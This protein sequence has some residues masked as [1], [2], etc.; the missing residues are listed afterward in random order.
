M[1]QHFGRGHLQLVALAPHRLDQDGKM[2]LAATHHAERLAGGRILHLQRHILEQFLMQAVTNLAAG[3]KFALFTRKGAVVDGKG[4]FDRRVVDLDEGQGFD[5]L[6]VAQGI[7]DVDVR[8][9][10]ER[11]D[12]A[13]VGG[14]N[15]SA[16]I[17]LKAVQRG[18]APFFGEIFVMPVAYG[19]LLAHTDGAVLHTPDADTAYKIVVVDRGAQHRKRRGGVALGRLDIIEDRLKQRLQILALNI[20][21]VACRARTAGAEYHRA[22][23]LL[24]RGAKVHQEQ[25]DLVDDFLDA[26]IGTV[27]LVHGDDKGKILL[28]GFLQHK[29]CL[30]H[31][32]LG[33]VHQKEHAVD[34]LQNAFHFAAE[35]GVARG[36]HDIDFHAVII[37]TGVFGKDGDAALAL[38]VAG[39]HYAL[40]NLLVFAERSA[41]LE[42]LVHER[43]LAV[44]DV[45]NDRDV[46][47]VFL[48]HKRSVPLFYMCIDFVRHNIL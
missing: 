5:H 15:G 27:D 19:H 41:L 24:V 16:A 45:G 30:G 3:D 33:G 31:A 42:H 11:D 47:N 12:I 9:A 44:V 23:Q 13:C 1:Q 46:A 36:V 17:G 22:V 10:A 38:D 25:K 29:A 6:R 28:Q 35:I 40:G 14:F 37:G 2:H 39:V 48:F 4:H 32:A 34:H 26:R 7:A 21:A 43:R 8:Q 20:G 18:D